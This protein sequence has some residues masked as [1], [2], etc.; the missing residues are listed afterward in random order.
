[1]A[2]EIQKHTETNTRLGLKSLSHV[3]KGLTPQHLATMFSQIFDLET[4][5]NILEMETVKNP[6][7][8][9]G[10]TP[11]HVAARKGNLEVFLL[12]KEKVEDINPKNGHGNTPLHRAALSDRICAKKIVE[13]IIQNVVEKNPVNV[14]GITPLHNAAISGRL[15]IFQLLFENI[16]NQNPIDDYGETP[17]HKA[18]DGTGGGLYKHC[19]FYPI[20]R[21]CEHTQIC[22]LILDNID[23]NNKNP[24]N[25]D[26]KTPLQMA[27]K[28]N[29]SLV[30][31]VLTNN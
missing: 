21:K 15:D 9:E 8:I 27:V 1:M 2:S 4:I 6:K 18:A 17:L 11:L 7:D 25:L 3:G 10:N 31:N 5:E 20:N 16:T 28:S 26:G 29:H 13:L 24:V 14:V 30:V 22:Q 23:N 19:Q 12:I